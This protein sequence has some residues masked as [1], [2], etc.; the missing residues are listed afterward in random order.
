MS[1]RAAQR[2]MG[3]WPLQVSVTFPA[4]V[5]FAVCPLSKFALNPGA[6]T[7]HDGV[8]FELGNSDTALRQVSVAGPVI[9]AVAGCGPDLS[10]VACSDVTFPRRALCALAV[11]AIANAAKASSATSEM[12][13]FVFIEHLPM[14]VDC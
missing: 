10:E 4:P 8:G 2:S 9:S 3:P 13:Y 1:T 14:V 5:S 11:Y 7:W 6:T 12:R